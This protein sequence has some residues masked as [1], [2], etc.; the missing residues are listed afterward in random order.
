M[1]SSSSEF[2]AV[3]VARLIDN[4]PTVYLRTQGIFLLTAH[5]RVGNASVERG[6]LVFYSKKRRSVSS[7][8][9]QTRPRWEYVQLRQCSVVDLEVASNIS[10]DQLKNLNFIALL[11]TLLDR[12]IIAQGTIS[13]TSFIG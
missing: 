6:H 9:I 8:V 5:V 1:T 10:F 3:V 4:S 13:T 2:R 11:I 12:L 7:F